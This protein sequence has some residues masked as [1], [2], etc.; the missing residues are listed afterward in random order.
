[1]QFHNNVSQSEKFKE[2][3]SEFFEE[4]SVIRRYIHGWTYQTYP[5]GLGTGA[6]YVLLYNL[7]YKSK[8][9]MN[10]QIFL[11]FV[12]ATIF[13]FTSL[14][15][16]LQAYLYPARAKSVLFNPATTI[17]VPTFAL[18]FAT[19][20][21]GL[22][23][24]GVPANVLSWVALE[25]LFYC[26][27]VLAL[28]IC[29]PLL[30]AW[31][32]KPHD[33]KTFT[34]AWAFLLFP[35]MLVGV[36]ASRI[37]STMPLDSPQAVSVLFLG[38][39]F[40]GL[41]TCMT[42]F[43]IPIYLSRI[44]QTGFMEGHQANG[45]FVMAGPPG[46][47][48]VALISLGRVAPEANDLQEMMT[49]EVG[50]VFFGVGVLMGIFLLGLCLVLFLMALIPYYSKLHKKLSEVLGLWA[51]T[52]PIV[53]MTTALRLLGDIFQSKA[54]HFGQLLMTIFVCCAYVT[55]L[56]C[57]ILALCKGEILFSSSEQVLR[58]SNRHRGCKC[59]RAPA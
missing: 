3:E 11:F 38:Y 36:V 16:A 24:Y 32:N 37:I 39:M 9:L 55:A 48:A 46:F 8:A 6:V 57:T 30:V 19:L 31:Y 56:T 15:L 23:N 53:G 28:V 18:N 49:E 14:I 42:F 20:I 26:Y 1:M 33:L 21:M 25:V 27:V 58:D 13:S 59:K 4:V 50:M 29:I 54:L 44:M 43:Y 40:Q 10:F 35:M 52:F 7:S 22:V 41:G 45:A 2:P 12:N 5:M 47:T 51:T 34:P 17:F